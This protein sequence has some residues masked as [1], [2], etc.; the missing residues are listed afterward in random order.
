VKGVFDLSSHN[1]LLMKL[2]WEFDR[3]IAD[4]SNPYLAHNFFVTAW[5][6]LEWKYPDPNGRDIRNTIRNQIPLL[7]ICEHLAVGA[8][9]FELSSAKHQSVLGSKR[10]DVWGGSW[11]EGVWGKGVWASWLVVTLNG[12]AQ[13]MYG[14]TI[15]VD[16]LARHVMD[17]WRTAK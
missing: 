6:L 12:D 16:D 9:H 3:L 1:D 13:E 17:Y 4:S 11:A 5:H 7:Q 14:D 10:S 2:E 8:K 15:K